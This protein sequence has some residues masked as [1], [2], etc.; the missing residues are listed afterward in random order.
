MWIMQITLSLPFPSDPSS[1]RQNSDTKLT[2]IN[3]DNEQA[4]IQSLKKYS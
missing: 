1:P 4:E 3:S 2:L